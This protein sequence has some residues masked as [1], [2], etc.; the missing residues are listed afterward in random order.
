MKTK[1]HTAWKT[2]ICGISASQ[3]G[4]V[5]SHQEKSK[6]GQGKGQVAAEGMDLCSNTAPVLWPL[7]LTQLWKAARAQVA[8]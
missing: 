4:S 7:C 3:G 2:V 6:G 8:H 1:L 5:L